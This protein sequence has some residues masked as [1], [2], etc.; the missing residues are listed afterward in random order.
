MFERFTEQA[1]RCLFFAHH[2]ANKCGATSIE[3]EHLLLGLLQEDKR[4]RR[5]LGTLGAERIRR[6]LVKQAQPTARVDLPFSDATQLALTNAAEECEA[7]EHEFIDSS[8]IILGLLRVNPS[9]GASLLEEYGITY[10]RYH[11][12][13]QLAHSP[14]SGRRKLRRAWGRPA[15]RPVGY[16]DTVAASL[17]GS[18]IKLAD[19]VNRTADLIEAQS[20]TYRHARLKR[21]PWSR[22]EAF[23]HLVDWAAAHQQWFA[24]ALTQPS[25][26]INA[27]PS[28][29]W[30]PA[31][32]Y[33]SFSW[34][35]LV[36]LW[37]GLNNLLLHV[38]T[39]IPEDKVNMTCRIGVE[40]PITLQKMVSR[41]VEHCEDVVGQIVSRL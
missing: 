34:P 26:Q 29:D 21:K 37:I 3:T 17:Q 10:K 4:L 30:V 2:E 16:R 20:K 9:G 24:C 18:F 40:K 12:L 31:Q 6:R 27:Y 38:L 22:K 28:E 33:R 14:A 8:H 39:Q 35:D 5:K 15:E 32:H 25:L 1:R 11:R 7:L 41:Y 13:I 19:L 36:D 23:G